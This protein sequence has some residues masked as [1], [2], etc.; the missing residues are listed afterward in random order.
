MDLKNLKY[1]LFLLVAVLA[2]SSCSETSEDESA[3]EY[4]NWQARN[5]EYFSKLYA[6]AQESDRII[7]WSKQNQT[8]NTDANGA[9][10]TPTYSTTDYI[11]VERKANVM[12]TATYAPTAVSPLYTDSVRVAYQGRL[13]PTTEHPDGVYFDGSFEGTYDRATASTTKFLTSGL[14]TGFTTALMQMSLGDHWIV[15]I[16]Y[17]L[18]YGSS[19]SNSSIP[20]YSMLRFEIV[21]EGVKKGNVWV[22]K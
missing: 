13:M 5:D 11:V 10:Y 22:T 21:L 19:T 20:A 7:S 16:P 1:L 12:E 14:I 15:Y 4:A 3:S 18:G 17:G 2:L 9:T 6:S 8:G